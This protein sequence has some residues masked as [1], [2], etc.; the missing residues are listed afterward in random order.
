MQAPLACCLLKD[1]TVQYTTQPLTTSTLPI[2]AAA[3]ANYSNVSAQWPGQ[4]VWSSAL[5]LQPGTLRANSS[6][7]MD[8][9][10]PASMIPAPASCP[11]GTI[12]LGP[13]P[14]YALYGSVSSTYTTVGLP[15]DWARLAS[16][17][18]YSS[19]VAVPVLGSGSSEIVGVLVA[20]DKGTDSDIQFMVTSDLQSS[21]HRP[22][23]A[24]AAQLVAGLG[25]AAS[26]TCSISPAPSAAKAQAAGGRFADEAWV[27]HFESIALW[28]GPAVLQDGW[29][30]LVRHGEMFLFQGH[31]EGRLGKG[32]GR[33]PCPC[34]DSVSQR[35]SQA[36]E[37]VV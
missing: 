33:V 11:A 18:G 13:P 2:I 5:P 20:A 17:F 35:G 28:L 34:V 25:F 6:I 1:G 3:H 29:L 12:T 16:L 10:D 9:P 4:G 21:A 30:S 27:S 7:T 14:P 31:G 23:T 32:E 24:S 22:L 8:T 37:M 19:F 15:G 26:A 36:S